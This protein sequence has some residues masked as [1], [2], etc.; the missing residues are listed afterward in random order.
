MLPLLCEHLQGIAV[1]ASSP[2]KFFFK[3][4]YRKYRWKGRACRMEFWSF[5]GLWFLIGIFA[6]TAENLLLGSIWSLAGVAILS[7]PRGLA[8][9]VRRLHDIG[10]SAQWLFLLAVPLIGPVTLLFFA[11]TEGQHRANRYGANPKD[12]IRV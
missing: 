4:V 12:H 5:W 7:L 8:L 1:E 9:T 6:A 10:R 2:M 11:V 3:K